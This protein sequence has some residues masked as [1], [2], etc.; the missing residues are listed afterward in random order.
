MRP[1]SPGQV[2]KSEIVPGDHL[3]LLVASPDVSGSMLCWASP[4]HMPPAA[5]LLPPCSFSS[6]HCPGIFLFLFSFL[7]FVALLCS[8]CCLPFFFL[9]FISSLPGFYPPYSLP[10]PAPSKVVLEHWQDLEARKP[11]VTES[12]VLIRDDSSGSTWGGQRQ[13]LYSCRGCGREEGREG[14]DLQ[15]RKCQE[16]VDQGSQSAGRGWAERTCAHL[17]TLFLVTCVWVRWWATENQV[18]TTA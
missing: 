15:H 18:C 16:E 1:T 8:S 7:L 5:L 11:Q 14:A 4:D 12:R 6:F 17:L 3:F 10:H 13:T 9:Y 2:Q